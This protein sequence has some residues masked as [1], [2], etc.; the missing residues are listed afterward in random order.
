MQYWFV[1][2]ANKSLKFILYAYLKFNWV[3]YIHGSIENN[4]GNFDSIHFL[5]FL[6]TSI[7]PSFIHYLS[8]FEKLHIKYIRDRNL[9]MLKKNETI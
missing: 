6:F 9:Y 3:N 4:Y 1:S 7:L 5:P 8:A 2:I